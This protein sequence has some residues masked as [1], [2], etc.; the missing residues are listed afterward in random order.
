MPLHYLEMCS[1]IIGLYM[2][3][4]VKELALCILHKSWENRKKIEIVLMNDSI[5]Y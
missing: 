4:N 3:Y 5:I 2:L 1:Y